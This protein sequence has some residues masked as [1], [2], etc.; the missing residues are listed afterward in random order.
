[1]NTAFVP[2]VALVMGVVLAA[3]PF[4]PDA[5]LAQSRRF[6]SGVQLVPLTVT[7]TDRAGRYVPD[8]T[9]LTSRCSKKASS[10]WCRTSPRITYHSTLRS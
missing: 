3:V 5:L 1:M 10:R 9:A 4:A 6:R 7:V 2:R 8:L